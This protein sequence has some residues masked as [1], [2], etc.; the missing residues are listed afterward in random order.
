MEA[1]D[2]KK[3]CC[4]TGH[5]KIPPG[6]ENPLR[7]QLKNQI[8]AFYAQGVTTF[9]VGGALGFDTLAAETVL[10]CRG[11]CPSL[12]L[13]IVAPHQRQADHWGPSDKE[14]Y[15]RIA[16]AADEFI[17]LADHYFQG[18]MQQR[19]RYLVDH[20][21]AC[22]CYLAQPTGGT[23]YTVRYAEKQGLQIFNLATKG[24]NL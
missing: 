12:R 1:Q 24:E 10:A 13:V 3:V 18:C 9:L 21:E 14:K 16:Q 15:L 23:A 7:E 6:L 4:F 5:R 19:N 22:I 20:S 17:C 8:E 2:R 11:I